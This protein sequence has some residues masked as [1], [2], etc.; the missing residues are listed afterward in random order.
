MEEKEYLFLGKNMETISKY[1]GIFLILWGIIISLLSGT[2]SPT[3]L[4]PSFLGAFI[5]VPAYLSIK[6]PEK[7][8]LYMHIVVA[9]GLLIF[10]GGFRVLSNLEGLF[11]D[12]FWADI[13]QIMMIIT[14]GIFTYLCV[15]SFI[16]ARKNK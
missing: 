6:F 16:F 15:Q 11:Q 3:A 5:L 8:K 1:Y 10:L 2:K 13:S 4:I 14:G 7:K 9:V 12:R